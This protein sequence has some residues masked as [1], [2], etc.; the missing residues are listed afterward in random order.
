MRIPITMANLGY[1]M[2]TGKIVSWS[3]QV[4]DTVE[5]GEV[6]AE[7]E[8]DKTNVE[9]ESLASGTLVE[10]T[11]AA[12]DEVPVDG[13]LVAPAVLDA[14][15]LDVRATA[16]ALADLAARARS[17]KLR[18]AEITDG[19]FTVSNLGMFGVSAFAA[20]VT[21]PQVAVLATGKVEQRP[22]WHD[23]AFVPAGVMSATLSSDHRAVDGA[24]AARFLGTLKKLLESPGHLGG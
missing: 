23:G 17:G 5:R 9:M 16:E 12:G 8:T 20:I 6:I 22:V 1:D 18:G 24:D 15:R 19:T 11:R 13:G 4:G 2:E 10:V 3:K 7:V 21:P 14:D